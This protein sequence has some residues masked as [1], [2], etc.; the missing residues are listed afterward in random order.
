MFRLC[1]RSLVLQLRL[2]VDFIILERHFPSTLLNTN[3]DE[4]FLIL[5]VTGIAND[6]LAKHEVPGFT[7]N[8]DARGIGSCTVVLNHI[9]LKSVAVT[10]HSYSLVAEKD[11]VLPVPA[12]FIFLQ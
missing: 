12:D 1:A 8:P 10:S 11:A 3:A 5:G 9:L 7:A 6:V 2:C 4:L